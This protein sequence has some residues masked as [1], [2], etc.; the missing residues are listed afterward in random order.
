ML[1]AWRS[2]AEV[3]TETAAAP[4][5]HVDGRKRRSITLEMRDAQVPHERRL[6]RDPDGLPVLIFLRKG[7]RFS[8]K[9]FVHPTAE[10][11]SM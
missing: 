7:E 1:R 6:N 11:A 10:R 8:E 4:Q 9:R 3:G 2:A 5:C